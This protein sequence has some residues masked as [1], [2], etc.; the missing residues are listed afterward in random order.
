MKKIE[1]YVKIL[2]GS[3]TMEDKNKFFEAVR[4]L[5]DGLYNL[6][7]EFIYDNRTSPQNRYYWGVVVKAYAMGAS[8]SSG[9][10]ISRLQAHEA[11]KLEFNPIEI[12]NEKTG[13]VKTLPG[14]TRTLSTVEFSEY[15]E[16]C[17]NFIQEWFNIETPDPE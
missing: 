14:S 10:P 16:N 12:I 8:E 11:M 13:E 17:R 9:K 3:L 4:S 15:T 7:L 1:A 6:V 2:K 5:P